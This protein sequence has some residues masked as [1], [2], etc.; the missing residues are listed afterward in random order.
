MKQQHTDLTIFIHLLP[1][2]RS[3]KYTGFK[4]WRVLRTL[5]HMDVKSRTVASIILLR[6]DRYGFTKSRMFKT[7]IEMRDDE[8]WNFINT[9]ESHYLI[10]RIS[11]TIIERW[12]SFFSVWEGVR[13]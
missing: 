9:K 4:A 13:W 6:N 11:D 12:K 3:Q 7:L 5:K 10:N 8:M 2:I 1:L